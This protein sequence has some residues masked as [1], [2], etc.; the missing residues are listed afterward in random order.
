MRKIL[1]ISI[2]CTILEKGVVLLLRYSGASLFIVIV[3]CIWVLK[4][5]HRTYK[6]LFKDVGHRCVGDMRRAFAAVRC[7]APRSCRRAV[8]LSGVEP[9]LI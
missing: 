8:Q 3:R 1:P 6:I 5:L 4:E 9:H 7:E 2:D